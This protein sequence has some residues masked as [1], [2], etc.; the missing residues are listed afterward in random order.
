MEEKKYVEIDGKKYVI[1]PCPF[2]K[3]ELKFTLEPIGRR[4]YCMCKKCNKK[5]EITVE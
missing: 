3:N 1:I 2:C 4:L 5:L